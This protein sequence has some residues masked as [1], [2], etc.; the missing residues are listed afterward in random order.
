MHSLDAFSR[1]TITIGDERAPV[2]VRK[3][4]E[5][6]E[7]DLPNLRTGLH[8]LRHDQSSIYATLNRLQLNRPQAEIPVSIRLRGTEVARLGPQARPGLLSHLLGTA[9]ARL[10][11][12]GLLRSGLR[13]R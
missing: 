12:R 7:I 6:V 11:L 3:D 9:P 2:V 8:K 5:R 10:R 4:G 1:L 13:R